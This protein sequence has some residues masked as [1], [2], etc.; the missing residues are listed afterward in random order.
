MSRIW[1]MHFF[2][3]SFLQDAITT[4][5]WLWLGLIAARIITHDAFEGR[6]KRLTLLT[7]S[8]ELVTIMAMAGII[9][10]IQ[11]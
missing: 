4:G 1:R 5:F 7:I 6:P 10:L 9:G 8:H 11:P 3:N 2:N